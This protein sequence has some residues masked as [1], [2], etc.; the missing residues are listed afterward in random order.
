MVPNLGF[1]QEELAFNLEI[2]IKLACGF[3]FDF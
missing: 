3:F 1:G 2:L